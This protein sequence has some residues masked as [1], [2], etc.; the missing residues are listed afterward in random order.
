MPSNIGDYIDPDHAAVFQH[1]A[2][3]FQVYLL[4]RSQNSKARRYFKKQ[5]YVPKRLDCKAKTAVIDLPP[6]ELAG[7]VADPTIHRAAFPDVD[8]GK[9]WQP[10][11]PKL[12]I[13]QA[14]EKRMYLPAGKHYTMQMN[15]THKHYGCVQFS[16][17][18]SMKGL[19]YVYGDY[20][21]YGIVSAK[22]PSQNVF[23]E[24]L[25]LGEKHSRSPEFFDVQ[26]HLNRRLDI[27]LILHGAQ[28]S[29]SEHTEEDILVFHPDG[30]KVEEK[31]GKKQIEEMYATLFQGR[32]VPGRGQPPQPFK[33]A[34]KR[35]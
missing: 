14:G 26:H 31:Q 30:I 2:R 25:R 16:R 17:Y 4:V 35:L 28:E 6:Y 13:P 5:D 27:P 15:P 21:L 22:N 24:E 8:A 1:A 12:Y 19:A 10:F 3:H 7:L 33:G 20:D 29:Y 9:Y 18:G 11:L 34:Y 32:Q 23:V